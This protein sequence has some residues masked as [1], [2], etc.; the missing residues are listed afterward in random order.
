MQIELHA[1]VPEPILPTTS[2]AGTR[3]QVPSGYGVQEHCL[4][5][6]AAAATGLLIRAPFSFGYCAPGAVPS[7]SSSARRASAG[8]LLPSDECGLTL[9]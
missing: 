5:F 1:L 7:S 4:P 6:T 8:V 9:L 2:S 3:Q